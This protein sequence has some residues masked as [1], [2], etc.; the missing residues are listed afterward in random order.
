MNESVKS[1]PV[2]RYYQLK[3][4]IRE[5]IRSGEWTPGMLIPSERELCERYGISRM[6]ARQAITELVNEGL[7]YR[8]QGKGTFVDR[9]RPK[10]PQQLMSLTGFTQD[11]RGREQR[12]GAH[13]LEAG[14]WDADGATAE[15]LR[16][17]PGQPVFRLRRLRLADTEP[18]AIETTR[19]N[20]IGCER[21]LDYDLE[22]DS[23]YRVLTEI[24]DMPPVAADQEIEADLA[25]AEEANLLGLTPGDPVLRTRRTTTTRRG[26]PIEF[27]VSLYRG[28]K[29]RFFT[30]LVRDLE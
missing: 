8:E 2:P 4:F 24:F 18:L 17:K 7:L 25:G 1:G 26:Q 29:Y 13:V 28:D 9:A 11:I 27:A 12:P 14:M 15:A 22:H 19:V 6:T 10:I 20:F 5:R 16:I 23:L 30:R 3:E 21:L